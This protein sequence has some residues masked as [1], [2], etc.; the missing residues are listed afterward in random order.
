MIGSEPENKEAHFS[1]TKKEDVFIL[2]VGTF[3]LQKYYLDTD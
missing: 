1:R 3:R 2:F